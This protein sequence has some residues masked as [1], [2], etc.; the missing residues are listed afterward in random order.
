MSLFNGSTL[1]KS[2]THCVH[3]FCTYVS[4]PLCASDAQNKVGMMH[5]ILKGNYHFD[6]V[7]WD[8]ISISAMS[9]IRELLKPNYEQRVHAVAALQLPWMVEGNGTLS[10]VGTRQVTDSTRSGAVQAIT[11]MKKSV[12]TSSLRRTSMLAVVF[13]ISQPKVRTL[14]NIICTYSCCVVLFILI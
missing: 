13:S 6:D 5:A 8:S 1:S 4:G 10:S 14:Y 3:T 9:F 2:F 11:N 7:I 12:S